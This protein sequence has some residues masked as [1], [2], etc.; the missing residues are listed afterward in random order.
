MKYDGAWFA[1]CVLCFALFFVSSILFFMSSARL[2]RGV[3]GG[4]VTLARVSFILIAAISASTLGMTLF[5]VVPV[6]S[7]GTFLDASLGLIGVLFVIAV[8]ANR[9]SLRRLV[10]SESESSAQT[11]VPR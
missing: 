1:L 10:R 7:L 6:R 11:Q 9:E 3:S 2:L 8:L 4:R 5:H